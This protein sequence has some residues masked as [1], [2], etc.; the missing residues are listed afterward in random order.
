[1]VEVQVTKDNVNIAFSRKLVDDK[2]LNDFI[3]KVRVKDL[4][5]RSRMTEEE[6]LK[7]DRELKSNW[8]K[9]NRQHFLAKMQ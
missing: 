6:A 2:E 4:I 8:W 3:E 1:M 7:L 9:K 5:T